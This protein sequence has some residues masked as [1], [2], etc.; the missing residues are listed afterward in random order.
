MIGMDDFELLDKKLPRAHRTHYNANSP[1]QRNGCLENTREAILAELVT[2][3]GDH[4]SNKIYWLSGMA[5]TGKTTIAYSFCEILSSKRMLAANFFCSRLE[6]ESSNVVHIFPTIAHQLARRFPVVSSALVATIRDDPDVGYKIVQQNFKDLIVQPLRAAAAD[7]EG[8][9]FVVVIDALDECTS[10][11]QVADLLLAI[12]RHASSLPLKFFVTSRPEKDIRKTFKRRGFGDFDNFILHDVERDVVSSDIELYTRYRLTD[13]ADGRSD[14]MDDDEWPPESQ[15]KALVT[16]SGSLFIYAATA[17]S[18]IAAGVDLRARLT[19]ITDTLT[20]T[21]KDGTISLDALYSSILA[22]AYKNANQM[23]REEI[24]KVLYAVIHALDPLSINSLSQLLRM[25]T[26]EIQSA[27]SCLHSLICVPRNKDLND[28]ITTFHSSFPDF[29]ND[30]SRS[31]DYHL[32]PTTSHQLLSLDCL[33]LMEGSFQS[34]E[35]VS[36]LRERNQTDIPQSLSY[37]ATFWA[38]HLAS[39][40]ERD[41]K[42]PVFYILSYKFFQTRAS[43][44]IDCSSIIGQVERTVNDLREIEKWA[45][46]QPLLNDWARDVRRFMTE[47]MEFISSQSLEGYSAPFLWLPEKSY[48]KQKYESE[49]PSPWKLILGQRHTWDACEAILTGHSAPV[50]SVAYSP[51][52]KHIVSGARDNIIRLWNAVTGEPEA[53]L[54]GHSSWVTSVAFSP[55]GAHIASASGDRTICSWNPETGE[56]ESQLKVHPTFV[57]SVS[58]SPDGRHGVS[59]LNENSICIWNT[60]TA[61]SEVELKGHSNWVESVA[62]SSNGK[63]VVSGSHDHT[64]RVWNSV[65][66]YPEANLKGHSSWVVSVAF[67]PDGNHIVSGS[68]DNS[69]RIW[70][71]TTWETEAELKGHSNGVNSVA[72]SSDGRRIV[73]ASDDSTVCLWNALTGELEATLRGHASWVASAVFSPNGAHVT[74][75]SGDKTVRIWNSC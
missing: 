74:S 11:S 46:S 8:T 22:A 12:A 28:P 16:L 68:S 1:A 27:L 45:E 33:E 37:A 25:T 49:R 65:T 57:R 72:Y 9:S 32:D 54:T 10:Q 5:G 59:G 50:V 34:K 3:A 24:Q 7:F 31:G 2:W 21:T 19:M 67:S 15:V 47:N 23:E 70:N 14:L 66:G 17:C 56:F 61:E 42:T 20:G 44:W 71:A 13:I 62:F 30:H 18:H 55:D 52:G 69:I 41:D 53:E 75:T 73:S 35:I 4:M 38:S 43:Q 29:V 60:V 64:V 36:Y 63:Y 40:Q 58:F 48:M 6:A 51:D 39:S 26:G